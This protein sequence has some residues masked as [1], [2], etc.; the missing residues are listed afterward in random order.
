[1]YHES[2]RLQVPFQGLAVGEFQQFE[3]EILL[4]FLSPGLRLLS[5]P[6]RPSPVR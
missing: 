2:G 1:M 6:L 3:E 4:V 5:Y